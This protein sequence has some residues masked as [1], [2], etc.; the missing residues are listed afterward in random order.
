VY[1]IEQ[2]RALIQAGQYITAKHLVEEFQK[3]GLD[4]VF[5][6]SI[7]LNGKII[8]EYLERERVLIAGLSIERMPTH[9]VCDLSVP[10]LVILLTGYIP[11]SRQWAGTKRR[12]PK[13]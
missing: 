11:D 4:P 9:V 6:N 1:D 2:I 5:A 12:K 8:E 3:D 7:I 10:G 13:R